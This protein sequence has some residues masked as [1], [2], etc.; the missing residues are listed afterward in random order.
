MSPHA[1][2]DRAIEAQ[3]RYYG[4]SV[5]AH[6]RMV[7]RACEMQELAEFNQWESHK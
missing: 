7:A 3:A 5:E 1:W 6:A 2:L 4:L